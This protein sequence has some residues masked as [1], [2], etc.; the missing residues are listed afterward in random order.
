LRIMRRDFGYIPGAPVI[1]VAAHDPQQGVVFYVLNQS[2]AAPVFERRTSC[3]SCHVSA[4]T[5]NVPGMIA[6][7][8]A[9]ADDG[10][11]L[12]RLGSNDVTHRT[13]HPDRWG[14]YLV[15]SE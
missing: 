4:T 6:R 3:L 9:V 2:S 12:P 11:L 13:P 14:G 1:E 10:S 7:S 5:L 8:N 15:T